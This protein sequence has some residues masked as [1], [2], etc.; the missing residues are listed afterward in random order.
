MPAFCPEG[1]KWKPCCADKGQSQM[2][3]GKLV[4]KPYNPKRKRKREEEEEDE[5]LEA[6]LLERHGEIFAEKDKG[7]G[8]LKPGDLKKQ[9]CNLSRTWRQPG[10][11]QVRL[12]RNMSITEYLR[13][14]YWFLEP[15]PFATVLKQSGMSE[16]TYRRLCYQ[17]RSIMFEKIQAMQDSLPLLGGRGRAV[18]IDE[19]YFTK[20]KR[21]RG[22]FVRHNL[23]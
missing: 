23:S 21:S 10:T 17:L 16:K 12:A 11:L 4:M 2:K 19:T 8:A 5:E 18:C 7:Q 22:G 9:P 14:L 3:C 1:H 20:K 15:V 6:F 13:A